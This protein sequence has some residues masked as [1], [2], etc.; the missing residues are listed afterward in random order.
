MENILTQKQKRELNLPWFIQKFRGKYIILERDFIII[1]GVDIKKNKLFYREEYFKGG[2]DWNGWGWKCDNEVFKQEYGF[3]YGDD[4]CMIY[5]YPC[6]IVKAL[7]ILQNDKK[8]KMNPEAYDMLLDGI[9][10]LQN[11]G[12][13]EIESKGLHP[14]PATTTKE[15]ESSLPIQ[16]NIII[17]DSK[18]VV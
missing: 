2:L 14:K 4:D 5:L 3:D 17:G 16:V 1:T 10:I 6:G 18:K 11:P 13:Q 9:S 8:V 12:K 7:R 15:S